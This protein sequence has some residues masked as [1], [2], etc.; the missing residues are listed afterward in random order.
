MPDCGGVRQG[1]LDDIFT[2]DVNHID[3]P[4]FPAIITP[5][6]NLNEALT[7]I[8]TTL[9]TLWDKTP[10]TTLESDVITLKTTITNIITLTAGTTL[11]SNLTDILTEMDNIDKKADAKLTTSLYDANTILK[12]D[13][14][15]T[16]L[17]LTIGANTVVGNIG[18]GIIAMTA[19][20][21]I[22]L[23]DVD[24]RDATDGFVRPYNN[25][26][27]FAVGAETYT[28]KV[29]LVPLE[30]A[31]YALNPYIKWEH[32]MVNAASDGLLIYSM[33]TMGCVIRAESVKKSAYLSAIS[34]G[35]GA[36]AEEQSWRL[37]EQVG[38]VATLNFWEGKKDGADSNTLKWIYGTGGATTTIMNLT[39]AGLW[40]LG[41]TTAVGGIVDEDNMASDSA[42]RLCTQQSIKAYAD[43]FCTQVEADAIEA[44]VGLNADGTYT[45]SV[46]SHYLGGATTLKNADELIDT[47]L[48]N[49]VTHTTDGVGQNILLST[50][51]FLFSDQPTAGSHTIYSSTDLPINAIIINAWMDVVTAF[52]ADVGNTCTIGVGVETVGAGAEDIKIASAIG[53]DY[54][55][56]IKV[57]AG[58]GGAT[59]LDFNKSTPIKLTAARDITVNVVL[60]G[61][62]TALTA[63]KFRVY[64]QYIL[65]D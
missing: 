31:T 37:E 23:I 29:L 50:G 14:D 52:T 11:Q 30:S 39:T 1:L 42:I 35:A 21:L 34:T 60:A 10:T 9:K 61:G 22:T 38:L 13:V 5:A 20:E 56:S 53:T 58:V 12:A 64:Q 16:P 47:I 40:Q 17:A 43:T 51:I 15:N 4:A 49:R 55:Q 62:A 41:V 26:D 46:S 44:G 63:G 3:A 28:P 19:V 59:E 7:N 8:A 65:S 45:A 2:S 48:Y 27:T 33:D 32:D 36:A 57:E 18:A 54:T 25:T 24:Y 6:A